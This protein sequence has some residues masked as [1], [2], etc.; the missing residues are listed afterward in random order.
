M[1]GTL[2]GPWLAI[3]ALACL[4]A[5]VARDHRPSRAEL[6]LLSVLFTGAAV[7]RLLAGIWGPLH[8]NG[9][10]PLW[11]RGALSAPVLAVTYGPGYFELLSWVARLAPAPDRAVFAANALLSAVSP[12]LLYATARAAGVAMAGA[13][14]AALLL[15]A[16]SVLIRTAATEAYFSPIAA[17]LLAVQLA[18]ALGVRADARRDRT[19]AALAALAAALFGAAA[20]RIHPVAYLPLA[21]TPL[22]AFGAAQRDARR[23][24]V[25]AAIAALAVGGGVLATSAQSIVNAL[26][27]SPMT[28][29]ALTA[30]TARDWQLLLA[31]LAAVVVL[32]RWMRPPWLPLVGVAALG[33]MLATASSF[34][35]HPVWQLAYRRLFWP[36]MLLGAAPVWPR[37]LS[38]PVAIGAAAAAAAV[39]AIGVAPDL[40]VLTTEQLEYAF[41]R[42]SL[43]DRPADCTI[44][45][46]TRAGARLWEI[47]SYLAPGNGTQRGVEREGD[48]ET[49]PGECLLYVRSSLCSSAEAR[50]VCESIERNAQLEPLA[51][52]VLPAAP[53]Y[54]DLPYD[55]PQVDVAVFRVTGHR[56]GVADGAA[57]SPA[58]AEAFYGRLIA[59]HESDDCRLEGL[60][61][62][63]FR[64]TVRLRTP[65]GE[66]HAVEVAGGSQP[67]TG[68]GWAVAPSDGA[69]RACPATVGG[70][71]RVLAE[72]G[73]PAARGGTE[74]TR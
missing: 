18:L 61:T 39:L 8:V 68:T 36:G 29:H 14:G 23:R 44:A 54:A 40:R 42:G 65:E 24:I 1:I 37:R 13:L 34:L 31:L 17:L 35:Q 3:A 15:A 56:R 74:P 2:N 21:I 55:R 72:L 70:L 6:A 73:D 45:A 59:L 25:R 19:A 51:T 28:S 32:H 46:V 4:V 27:S 69:Q 16:D 47:P 10:G 64:M 30:L 41:L 63:R 49:A 22:V 26:R 7:A 53:S 9:Q 11:V 57:I 33:L 67:G 43:R 50:E 58:F 71:A 66:E 12:V 38:A 48:L 52:R 20:A 5:V 60:T 62:S